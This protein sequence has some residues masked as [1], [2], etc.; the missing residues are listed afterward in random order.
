MRIQGD[1]FKYL[2]LLDLL[3]LGDNPPLGTIILNT[4]VSRRIRQAIFR[5][6]V[7]GY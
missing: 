2:I 7:A 1:A 5:C 6:G 3:R 4:A